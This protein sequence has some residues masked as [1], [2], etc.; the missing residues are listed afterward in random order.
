M[1]QAAQINDD[2][3]HHHRLNGLRGAPPRI[4]GLRREDSHGRTPRRAP[5][6]PSNQP[7]CGATGE[8]ARRQ[9]PAQCIDERGR[10]DLVAAGPTTRTHRHRQ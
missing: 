2:E 5:A 8:D 1:A 9:A 6:V 4:S 10:I 7:A 3:R